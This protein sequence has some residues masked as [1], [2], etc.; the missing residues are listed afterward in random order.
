ME[1]ECYCECCMEEETNEL[2]K[3]V[4]CSLC[5]SAQDLLDALEA[6]E[7]WLRKAHAEDL[8]VGCAAEHQLSAVIDGTVKAI[9]KARGHS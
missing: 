4:K 2:P 8:H 6:A 3:I 7:G 5:K 1:C 9:S